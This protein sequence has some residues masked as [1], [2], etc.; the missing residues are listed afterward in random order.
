MK[1]FTLVETLIAIMVL[2][3]AVVGPFQV[4]QGV[5]SSAYIARDQLIAAA[6]AQEGM[7]Y[8]REIR[9]SNYLYN[10]HHGASLTWLSGFDGTN[11]PDCYANAC[12]VD[13]SQYPGAV[14]FVAG[15]SVI[16]CGD[17]ICN[18]RKLYLS[19]SNI[20]NQQSSGAVTK[21]TRKMQLTQISATETLLT[22]TVSWSEHGAHSVVLTEN[23]RNWL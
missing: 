21:F 14:P 8:V 6:L 7:E 20:Y 3:F 1:G 22:V 12:V 19:T 23:L 16:S 9:D 15:V 2:T 17:T 4:A 13:P 10:A 5:L 11:G 18:N